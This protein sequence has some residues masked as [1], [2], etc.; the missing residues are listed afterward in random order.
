MFSRIDRCKPLPQ[1]S[2]TS[3]G[4]EQQLDLAKLVGSTSSVRALLMPYR[5][6]IKNKVPLETI[7]A[8][9]VP[10]MEHAV[11]NQTLL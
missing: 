9:S 11:L 10:R 7:S 3:N 4:G 8:A 2:P 5:L 1:A 6:A